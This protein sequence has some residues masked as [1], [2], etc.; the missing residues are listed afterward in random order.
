MKE[1]TDIPD[2]PQDVKMAE[3]AVKQHGELLA[4]DYPKCQLHL[5]PLPPYKSTEMQE[6]ADQHYRTKHDKKGANCKRV[7][8]P[9]MPL[10][11][12]ESGKHLLLNISLTV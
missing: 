8:T 2:E 11:G 1:K 9:G 6:E 4:S 7:G 10:A 12:Q 5:F 3:I